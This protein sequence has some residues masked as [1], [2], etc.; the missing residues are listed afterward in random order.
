MKACAIHS[1]RFPSAKQSRVTIVAVGRWR[2]GS[3]KY[4]SF[5]WWR[6]ACASASRPAARRAGGRSEHLASSGI[7]KAVCLR[8]ELR[9]RLGNGRTGF[10]EMGLMRNLQRVRTLRTMASRNARRCYAM[11]DLFPAGSPG[12]VAG[13]SSCPK[14]DRAGAAPVVSWAVVFGKADSARSQRLPHNYSRHTAT[15]AIW[16]LPAVSALRGPICGCLSQFDDDLPAHIHHAFVASP[17]SNRGS[18]SQGAGPKSTS[19]QQ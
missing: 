4:G 19:Q 11:S 14:E 3:G 2:W 7:L 9:R 8:G 12:G 13:R 6:M 18:L 5:T 1:L 16:I 17:G 10:S 15:S